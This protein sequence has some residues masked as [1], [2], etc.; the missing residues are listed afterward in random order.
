M[1]PRSGLPTSTRREHPTEPVQSTKDPPL[2]VPALRSPPAFRPR[3]APASG[4]PRPSRPPLARLSVPRPLPSSA[5]TPQQPR[6]VLLRPPTGR[7]PSRVSPRAPPAC[8]QAGSRSTNNASTRARRT[9][10]LVG[11][12]LTKLVANK[13]RHGPRCA[14]GTRLEATDANER[15]RANSHLASSGLEWVTRS[16]RNDRCRSQ[17]GARRKAARGTTG[18]ASRRAL[19]PGGGKTDPAGRGTGEGGPRRGRGAWAE[20]QRGEGGRGRRGEETSASGPS[21]R[22]AALRS[23]PP[24]ASAGARPRAYGWTLPARVASGRRDPRSNVGVSSL[25]PACCAGFAD[26][27]GRRGARPSS[28]ARRLRGARPSAASASLVRVARPS[29]GRVGAL[30]ASPFRFD[31]PCRVRWSH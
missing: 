17:V 9:H 30:P 11:V 14:R 1:A 15:A 20:R 21:G 25:S 23:P 3:A 31:R 10:E 4:L 16:E 18:W 5:P 12:G 22:S 19:T 7:K 2:H 24:A 27:S 26:R 13:G 29:V 28:C 8:S 6:E